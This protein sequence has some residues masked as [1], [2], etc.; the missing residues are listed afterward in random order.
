[1]LLLSRELLHSGKEEGPS[2]LSYQIHP[3]QHPPLLGRARWLE[4]THLPWAGY[5]SLEYINNRFSKVDGLSTE[6]IFPRRF[7]KHT[8][9]LEHQ[10]E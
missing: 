5:T 9:M 4:C 8:R 10:W 6:E 2:Y 7:Q 3:R 1:M